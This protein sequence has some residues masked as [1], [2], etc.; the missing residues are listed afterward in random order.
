MARK[1]LGKLVLEMSK[2][3][4][5][6]T[7]KE[8]DYAR[9]IF[10]TSGY[11]KK[12][13]EVWCHCCGHVE[14][15][16]PGMLDI[17]LEVGYQCRCLQHLVLEYQPR[18]EY[19]TEAKYYS[20]VQT[21]NKWQ[22][23]RTFDV[24][25]INRKN[26]PTEYS[27]R[28]V[29]QN[30]VSP[31]GEEVIISKRYSRG[32]NFFHWYYDT[33]YT[34][35]QHNASC[36]GYYAFEDVFDVRDNYFYPQY[37]IT[38]KLH[39]Y[40]WC[41]A[42]EKLPW[43]SVIECMKRLLT[44]RHAETV[45]KQGQY[46]V[47][48]Y[49]VREKLHELQYM[50]SLNICHRNRYVISDASMYFDMLSF[51]ERTGKDIRNPKYICP[52]DLYNAHNAAQAAYSKIRK[53]VE[54]EENRKRALSENAEYVKDKG[55]FFG[56]LIADGELSIQVL[57]SVT[58]FFE[59][60]ESMHH[61]VFANEYYKKKDS[62]ILSAKVAGERKETIE[63]NLK[64]FSIVQSRSAFNKSSEYHARIIELMNKNMNLIRQCV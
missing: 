34:I 33:E 23:I 18:K 49:M 40:G 57:K 1:S 20:V 46:D 10:P 35:K 17:D 38:K 24:H 50:P 64:T 9:G 61:C 3:L 60:G 16:L 54:A 58:E 2:H 27:I 55:K 53:K 41:K 51:L 21:Y 15:Q 44:S 36:S 4:K 56:V 22:V 13:G 52:E 25:R 14:N 12:D 47:F 28:E 29:Y 6:L 63:V 39:K 32:C 31:D 48:L 42:L 11:Y 37:N 5:P 7:K 45:V 62:L 26:Y 59:E 43:V 8:K 19:L 30:W